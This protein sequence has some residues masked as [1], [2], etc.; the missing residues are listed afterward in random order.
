MKPP[1]PERAAG[2]GAAVFSGET[3]RKNNPK[4]KTFYTQPLCFFVL[5]SNPGL[6]FRKDLPHVRIGEKEATDEIVFL[7]SVLVSIFLLSFSF[8]SVLVYVCVSVWSCCDLRW[9]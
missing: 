4:I 3:H 6:K 7:C 8:A 5:I 1:S 9:F 2:G